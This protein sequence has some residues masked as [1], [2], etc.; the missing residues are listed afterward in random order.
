MAA[1]ALRASAMNSGV[2]K[3][4]VAD[5]DDVAQRVAVEGLRQQVEEAAEI[6]GVEFLGRR[7][8]PE[9]RAELV[10]SSVMP[11]F[12]KRRIESPA[13]LSTRRLTA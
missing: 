10:P 4:V 8:L 1:P 6:G 7:E 3:R 11:D 2:L 13:S 9:Q 5:L 12:R